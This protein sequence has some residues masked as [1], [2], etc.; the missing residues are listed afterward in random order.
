[1][2]ECEFILKGSRFY[3]SVNRKNLGCIA[4]FARLKCSMWSSGKLI[5]FWIFYF[6]F[7]TVELMK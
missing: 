6:N 1:M 7:F 5:L 2:R 4:L 3:L